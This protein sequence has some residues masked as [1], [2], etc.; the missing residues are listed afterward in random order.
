ME[1]LTKQDI[2]TRAQLY[3]DDSSELSDMEFSDLFDTKYAE[4]NSRKPWEGTKK[5]ASGTTSV[6]L[7]YVSVP[8]DFRYLV[9]NANH[10]DSSYASSRPVI[11]RGTS[12]TPYQVVSWSDRRQYRNQN[13]YA[14]IDV[15]NS[16]LYFTEQPTIAESYEFDYHSAM[17]KLEL[18]DSPWFPAEFHAILFHE[19]VS[20]DYIIQQSNKAESYQQENKALAE[21]YYRNMEWYNAHLIQM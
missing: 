10:T 20:D 12:Y 1:P 2:I 5:E 18:A 9:Q 15:A 16:R 7:Q 8:A 13:G 17:P 3:L 19:M 11:F 21:T 6:S 4:L 14:Y